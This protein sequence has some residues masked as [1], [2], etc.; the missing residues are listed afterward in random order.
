MP[1]TLPGWPSCQARR[2]GPWITCLPHIEY[3]T[4]ACD[5]HT[6]PSALH[7]LSRSASQAH[8]HGAP[9][10]LDLLG[11]VFLYAPVEQSSERM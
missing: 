7:L 8:F 6:H 1:R 2:K 3:S 5:T 4:V 9:K 11:T 10:Q